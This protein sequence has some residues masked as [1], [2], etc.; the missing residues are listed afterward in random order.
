MLQF[1]NL[2]NK[3]DNF[4]GDPNSVNENDPFYTHVTQTKQVPSPYPDPN[5]IMSEHE[6]KENA[7][8]DK[9]F[10]FTQPKKAKDNY[11]GDPDTVDATDP[12]YTHITQRT[13]QK[14]TMNYI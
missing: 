6:I 1:K 14:V 8:L 10:V 11:D 5:E 2:K 13:N 4:D 9:T 7:K 12:Y 3:R